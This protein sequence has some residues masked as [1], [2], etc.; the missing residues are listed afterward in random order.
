MARHDSPPVLPAPPPR[1]W[2]APRPSCGPWNPHSAASATWPHPPPP[3][4][5][6]PAAHTPHASGH[7][8]RPAVVII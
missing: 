6:P 1:L 8:P 5:S 7:T 4:L 3:S 2:P